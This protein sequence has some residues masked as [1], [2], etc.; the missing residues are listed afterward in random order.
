M[1]PSIV[2]ID[3]RRCGADAMVS[4]FDRGFTHGDGVFEVLRTYGRR[5]FALEEHLSRLQS[6]AEIIG[7]A[8]PVSPAQVRSEVEALLAEAPWPEAVVRVIVSRGIS[9]PGVDPDAQSRPQ[10]VVIVTELEPLRAGIYR[11]G[12]RAITVT[13]PR[14]C[15]GSPRSLSRAKSLSFLPSMSALRAARARGAYEA[16][17]VGADGVVFEAATANVFCVTGGEL[18]TPS[19]DCGILAG[20]TRETILSAARQAGLTVVESRLR[21]DS[22]WTAD[23]AFVTASLREVVPIVQID[24]HQVGEGAPGPITQTLHRALRR[25]AGATSA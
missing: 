10:R 21:T 19:L 23:E 2:A 14:V 7:L 12:A 9:E 5:P 1:K 3:G 13:E 15:D 16:I 17:R 20:I 22:L 11:D 25:A 24:D 8:L 4:V 6:S 18:H